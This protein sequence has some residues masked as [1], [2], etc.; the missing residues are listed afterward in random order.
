[1]KHA[2]PLLAGVTAPA[3]LTV[4][5]VDR[6]PTGRLPYAVD[7]DRAARVEDWVDRTLAALR[8]RDVGA[9]E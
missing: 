2:T 4:P 8:A 6:S 9:R 3:A 1:M 7:P 5:A